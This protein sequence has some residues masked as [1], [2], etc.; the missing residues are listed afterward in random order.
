MMLSA[1]VLKAGDDAAHEAALHTV[2]FQKDERAFHDDG[3]ESR[4][5]SQ[6]EGILARARIPLKVDV[7]VEVI[8][9]RNGHWLIAWQWDI[10]TGGRL[11][12]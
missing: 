7:S 11:H 2:G 1:L 5:E 3:R 4:V 12:F 10:D 9:R 8:N 6:K